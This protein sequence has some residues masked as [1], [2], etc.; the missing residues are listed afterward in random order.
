[1]TTR[2][3]IV[4]AVIVVLVLA[5]VGAATIYYRR[6]R[7]VQVATE[8]IRARDLEAIVSASGR[9]QPKRQVNISANTMGKVTRLAVE[10]GQR[11]KAGQFLLEI[12]PRSLAGQLERGEASIAAAQ[13]SLQSGRTAVESAN[14]SL[15]LARTNLKRQ[16]EL[17]KDGLTTKE[18]LERAQNE[19]AA[20]ESDLRAREQ[21][22][23][24]RE[25]QI[26]QEQA[27][28]ATTRYN[29][30]QVIISSPM[31]GLVTR[32]NIE[33]GETA[34]VGTMNN[35]GTV[36]LTIAD[37]S[38][39]E[40]E[41]E[42]DETDIPDVS[43]GQIAKVKI[44]AVPDREFKGRV[45]EIANSP[46]QT[47]TS[48]TG[49]RQA[50]TFKVVV[51]IDEE[52]PDVRPGFTCTAEIT[53]ATRKSVVSVPIQALTVR[54]LLY[55]NA[56]QLVREPPPR[57]KRSA[58]EDTATRIETPE[59]HTR[60]ETEGVFLFR[61]GKAVFTPLK[62]GV[63]GE[64]FFEVTEGLKAGDQVITG[65]FASVRQLADGEGVR[66]QNNN[67]SSRASRASTTSP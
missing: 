34:V 62:T 20:R 42:V 67:T 28:L 57:R 12:D 52:V 35:A 58:D 10:E 7:G 33:E 9:I 26:K 4:I 8:A 38:V 6:D 18:A 51:T 39:L 16:Q 2:T 63:A 40:A 14:I 44:D 17:W 64:Q 27:G 32:R 21:E 25:Q 36:L 29:L 15:D 24:T 43:L 30:S 23:K 19:V 55:T 60:K 1:M 31:D 47:T 48:S 53:T 54:D 49:Q 45:T 37:M 41:I 56:G 66:L 46:I 3:K 11:V 59:G 13:S 22:I 50:T 65:P 61:E 5:G